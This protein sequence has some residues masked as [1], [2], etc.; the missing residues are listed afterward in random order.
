MSELEQKF[1][2]SRPSDTAP[3]DT[4]PADTAPAEEDPFVSTR[5]LSPDA[6]AK[7]RSGLPFSPP[8]KTEA[9]ASPEKSDQPQPGHVL[10]F[11][12]AVRSDSNPSNDLA[13]LPLLSL[14]QYAWLCRRLREA[15]GNEEEILAWMGIAPDHKSKLDAHWK[16]RFEEDADAKARFDATLEKY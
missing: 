13:D 11:R 14:D 8:Q 12:P 4:A 10:P 2:A 6:L 1:L 15:E 5:S 3:P 16:K 9:T 7:A